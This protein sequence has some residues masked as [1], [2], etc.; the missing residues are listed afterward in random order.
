MPFEDFHEKGFSTV[1]LSRS[2]LL[3]DDFRH[4]L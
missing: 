4:E 1:K 3:N 2:P